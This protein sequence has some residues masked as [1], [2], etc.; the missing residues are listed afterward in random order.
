MTTIPTDQIQLH[1]P[2]PPTNNRRPFLTPIPNLPGEFLL[3]LDNT[4]LDKIK[5]CHQ[6]ARNYLQL[7]REA[8]SKTAALVF[9]GAFHEAAALFHT[10]EYH[11]GN[12]FGDASIPEKHG[13]EA[14]DSAILKHFL[15]HPLPP[16]VIQFDYRNPTSALEVFKHYRSQCTPL[17]HPDYEWE[18]LAD[19]KGPII[20]RPFELP[21]AVLE[22]EQFPIEGVQS[23][24]VPTKIHLAWSGRIDLL[25]SINGRNHVVDHKTSSID[26]P[27]YFRQ[28]E[29]SS[30]VRGYIWA[31]SKLWPELSPRSFCHN[32]IFFKKNP[33]DAPLTA[34]GPR[35]GNPPLHFQRTYYPTNSTQSYSDEALARW[36]RDT[37]LTIEDFLHSVSRNVF[38]LNDNSCIQKWGICEYHDC[39]RMDDEAMGDRYLMSPAYKTVSWN[40]T[41]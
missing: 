22:F 10:E 20:E 40:P 36:E 11:K 15:D 32:G 30:Q 4:S 29:L 13:K 12:Q 26:A 6:A 33:G 7:G 35:G 2:E 9:G 37:I 28:F 41:N 25:A 3:V 21:L 18:I 39:C 27:D 24:G 14:Q 34:R 8:H 23:A 31:A 5:R 19:D 16:S 17:L 38:P 1:Q